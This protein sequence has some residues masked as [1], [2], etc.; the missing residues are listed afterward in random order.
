[1]SLLKRRMDL[2]EAAVGQCILKNSSTTYY[3]L[4]TSF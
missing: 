1:M 4:L 3:L 2:D